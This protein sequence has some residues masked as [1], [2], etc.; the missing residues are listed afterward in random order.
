[1]GG[2][3]IPYFGSGRGHWPTKATGAPYR[4]EAK[5]AHLQHNP[6]FLVSIFIFSR[7]LDKF[8]R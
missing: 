8:P 3:I 1:M 2:E 6:L 4:E 7:F 5:H